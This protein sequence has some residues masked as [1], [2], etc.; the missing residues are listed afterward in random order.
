MKQEIERLRH[1]IGVLE[2]ATGLGLPFDHRDARL[3]GLGSLLGVPAAVWSL[4]G[5]TQPP[6]TGIVL[7]ATLLSVLGAS[8]WAARQARKEQ[9]SEPLRWREHRFSIALFL[10]ITLAAHSGHSR[11]THS[12][13]LRNTWEQSAPDPGP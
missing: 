7:V 3:V 2:Q 9:A 4:V 6:I 8:I 13:T 5:P 12:S 11:G 1:D 10:F